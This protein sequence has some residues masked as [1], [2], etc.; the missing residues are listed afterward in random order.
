[1]GCDL[2]ETKTGEMIFWSIPVWSGGSQSDPADANDVNSQVSKS[3]A[4]NYDTW[5]INRKIPKKLE[6]PQKEIWSQYATFKSTY[7]IW[8]WSHHQNPSEKWMNIS[9]YNDFKHI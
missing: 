5:K 8:F 9:Y 3:E 6:T 4:I 1:M 7:P 2:G